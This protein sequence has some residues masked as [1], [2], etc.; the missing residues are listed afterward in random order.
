MPEKVGFSITR[1]NITQYLYATEWLVY[2][3]QEQVTP[4]HSKTCSCKFPMSIHIKQK[5]CRITDLSFLNQCKEITI[6]C[7]GSKIWNSL[8]AELNN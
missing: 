5:T 4:K 1:V 2:V 8:S 7:Q 6:A 3:L